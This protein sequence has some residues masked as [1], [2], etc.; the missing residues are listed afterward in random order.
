MREWVFKLTKEER[1]LLHD[2]EYIFAKRLSQAE[3]KSIIAQTSIEDTA[4]GRREFFKKF[5]ALKEIRLEST[6]GKKEEKLA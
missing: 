4:L 6:A 2:Y 5:P 3:Y 1:Q